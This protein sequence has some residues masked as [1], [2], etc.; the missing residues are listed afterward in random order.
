MV[1]GLVYPARLLQPKGA[2]DFF[3]NL[4]LFLLKKWDL[5]KITQGGTNPE[6]PFPPTL[7]SSYKGRFNFLYLACMPLPL[8]RAYSCYNC[9]MGKKNNPE[10]NEHWD[11]EHISLFGKYI[12]L[13]SLPE[14]LIYVI[15]L[16]NWHSFH[17]AVV[18][19]FYIVCTYT[20]LNILIVVARGC[21]PDRHCL[22]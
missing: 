19:H 16:D 5:I 12:F 2:W 11:R 14:I 7:S 15:S 22:L 20:H 1:L 3:L 6:C 9:F 21:F 13:N 10:I 8:E 18:I 4:P 17:T